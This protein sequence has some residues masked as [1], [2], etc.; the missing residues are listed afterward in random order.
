MMHPDF[1]LSRQ[2]YCTWTHHLQ[3]SSV[4]C[5][6]RFRWFTWRLSLVLLA[7][8]LGPVVEDDPRQADQS[9]GHG[10]HLTALHFAVRRN[11]FSGALLKGVALGQ[12]LVAA[13]PFSLLVH[14][15]GAG[16]LSASDLV[17]WM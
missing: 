16:L 9:P 7:A 10:Q 8:I 15:L 17:H 3:A 14:L 13:L 1:G 11:T 2:H 4:S 6:A 12:L 5:P